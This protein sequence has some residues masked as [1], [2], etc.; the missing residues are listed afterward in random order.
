MVNATIC[1]PFQLPVLYWIGIPGSLSSHAARWAITVKAA[2]HGI[3]PDADGFIYVPKH[4]KI[5]FQMDGTV[6]GICAP[7]DMNDYDT[8]RS[9]CQVRRIELA[10]PTTDGS[11]GVG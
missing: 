11:S 7:E 5:F 2:Q 9:L 3:T 8:L 1:I 10:D 6:I 4:G